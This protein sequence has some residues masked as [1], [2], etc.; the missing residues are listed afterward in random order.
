MKVVQDLFQTLDTQASSNSI[1]SNRTSEKTLSPIA[2]QMKLS[3]TYQT[4]RG[5]RAM[6]AMAVLIPCVLL[7]L[8]WLTKK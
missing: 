7:I 1:G 6:L 5:Q 4:N 2:E 8:W 3:H